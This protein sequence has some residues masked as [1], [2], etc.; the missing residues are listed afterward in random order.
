ML[1]RIAKL[2]ESGNPLVVAGCL[3][4]ADRLK[5]ESVNPTASLIGPDTIEKITE[6]VRS[7]SS[8][9]KQVELEENKS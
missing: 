2:S 8:G 7:A 3:P 6:V 5:V 9:R 4:K 1:H